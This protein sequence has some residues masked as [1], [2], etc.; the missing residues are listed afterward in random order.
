M[1]VQAGLCRTWS[2]T[3]LL[4]FL[5]GGSYI[6][7]KTEKK[8]NNRSSRIFEFKGKTM[9]ISVGYKGIACKKL[10]FI[11][12]KIELQWR[13]LKSLP[14]SQVPCV[15]RARPARGELSR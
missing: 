5:R 12:I 6:L 8:H 9:I 2:E 13:F 4:V 7:N 14:F 1:T 15:V 10:I 3:T 11:S